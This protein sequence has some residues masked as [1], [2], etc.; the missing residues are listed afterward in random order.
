MTSPRAALRWVLVVAGVAGAA[1][2]VALLA[3]HAARDGAETLEMARLGTAMRVEEVVANLSAQLEPG[4][5]VAQD[6]SVVPSSRRALRR[7]AI[8]R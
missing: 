7:F 6:A 1:A 3:G 5:V 8:A 2:L 4:A